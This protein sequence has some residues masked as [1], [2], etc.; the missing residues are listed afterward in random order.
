[1]DNEKKP[2]KSV[3]VKYEPK[4]PPKK[5]FS[6]KLKKVL[7]VLVA[8]LLAAVLIAG[9][10]FGGIMYQRS[11]EEAK[12]KEEAPVIKNTSIS[13]KVVELS[14]LT[15]AQLTYRGLI[16]FEEG[17]V[18][19]VNKNKYFM[20]Y[21][22]KVTAGVDFSDAKVTETDNGVVIELPKAKLLTKNIDP[23]TLEFYDVKVAK[24]NPPSREDA[25]AS[26]EAAY[27]DLDSSFDKRELLESADAQAK[28][29][30]TEMFTPLLDEGVILTVK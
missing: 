14:Q 1:M 9:G 26:L 11:R 30:V 12:V 19:F 6:K 18:P 25:V 29:M 7:K 23:D 16:D 22:A 8:L 2:I 13:Q 27:E 5:S 4:E 10:I 21:T 17:K 28:R 20:L 24:I 15:T 3:T